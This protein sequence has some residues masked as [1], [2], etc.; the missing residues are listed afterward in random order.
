MFCSISYFLCF[1]YNILPCEKCKINY[2]NNLRSLPIENHLDNKNTLF[3]WLI[4]VH[5]KVN[6]ESGK[7]E[8]TYDEVIDIYENM[9]DKSNNNVKSNK[10]FIQ[11]KWLYILFIVLLIILFIYYC[12]K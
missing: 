5:N 6:I 9:Y 10:K 3:N 12:K 4:D 7:K 2:L 1:L 8:L 11:N